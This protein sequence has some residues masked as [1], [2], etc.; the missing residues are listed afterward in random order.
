MTHPS[1]T[2]HTKATVRKDDNRWQVTFPC[3]C[4]DLNFRRA[5]IPA[6]RRRLTRAVR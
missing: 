3:D 5:P 1:D 2:H 6:R 4:P